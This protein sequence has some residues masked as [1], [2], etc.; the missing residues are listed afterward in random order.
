MG[1]NPSDAGT[2]KTAATADNVGGGASFAHRADQM[3]D[4]LKD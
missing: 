4:R 2:V 3:L 1:V